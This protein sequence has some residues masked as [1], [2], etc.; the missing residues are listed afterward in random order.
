VEIRIAVPE[1]INYDDQASR[2]LHCRPAMEWRVRMPGEL[3]AKLRPG[4]AVVISGKPK[5]DSKA[6]YSVLGPRN[7]QNIITICMASASPLIGSIS[8]EEYQVQIGQLSF[9][10]PYGQQK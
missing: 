1:D 6:N 5:F 10:S 9:A 3:A 2:A 4:T 8:M 7:A